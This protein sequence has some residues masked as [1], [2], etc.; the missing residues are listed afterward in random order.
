MGATITVAA[1][2]AALGFSAHGIADALLAM[3]IIATCLESI[4]AYCL[5]CQ[6]FSLLMRAGIVPERVCA[7]CA[8]VRATRATS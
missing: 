3:L 8:D 6:I 7:E 4:F 2:I 1:G 5:G